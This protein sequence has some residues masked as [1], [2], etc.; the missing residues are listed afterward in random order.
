MD[1]MLLNGAACP[2]VITNNVLDALTLRTRFTDTLGFTFIAAANSSKSR[3]KETH[4][5]FGL[6]M[7]ESIPRGNKSPT[8]KINF[9]HRTV[10]CE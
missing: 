10:P 9:S 3:Q 2:L 6:L 1:N 5:T 4:K 8:K 7:I